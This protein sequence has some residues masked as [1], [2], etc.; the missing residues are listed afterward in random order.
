MELLDG[1]KMPKNRL[2]I[3]IRSVEIASFIPGRIR[4]YSKQVKGNAEMARQVERELLRFEELSEI[5]VNPVTGSILIRYTPQLL[6][7]NKELTRVE[8]YIRTHVK[9]R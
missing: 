8:D 1:I 5:K 9:K 7:S 4:L 3:F 2:D 6:H